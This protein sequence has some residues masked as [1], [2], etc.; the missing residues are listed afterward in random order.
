MNTTNTITKNYPKNLDYTISFTID[1]E[2]PEWFSND[3]TS[4]DPEKC[5]KEIIK[6][7][8]PKQKIFRINSLIFNILKHKKEIYSEYD[9][10]YN[11]ENNSLNIIINNDTNFNN[12]TKELMLNIFDFAKNAEIDF[13]CMLISKKNKKYLEI[14]KEILIVGFNE[15]EQENKMILNNN[16][17]KILKLAVKELSNEIEDVVFDD[18]LDI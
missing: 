15:D 4:K 10:L 11:E 9:C 17:Y 13:I 16:E 2:K 8:I 3:F 7:A 12:F 14:I 5:T 1:I 6:S 18:N